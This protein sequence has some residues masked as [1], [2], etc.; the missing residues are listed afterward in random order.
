MNNGSRKKLRDL[1]ARLRQVLESDFA[2]GSS[3]P[4]GIK[5]K[6]WH[7]AVHMA[8]EQAMTTRGICGGIPAFLA[9]AA[10]RLDGRPADGTLQYCCDLIAAREEEHSPFAAVDSL[11]WLHQYW[12]DG[13]RQAITVN[14]G[15]GHYN[16]ITADQIIP[17][18]QVYSERYIVDFLVQ[19]SLG[20]LW[21]GMHPESALAGA[22]RYYVNK[23][24]GARLPVKPAAAITVVDPAC[25]CGNFLLAAFDLLYGMHREEGGESPEKI[26]ASILNDN[27][28]GL[29]IDAEAVEIAR[30]VLWLRAKE[31]APGLSVD[32][33]N[34][35]FR[36]LVAAGTKELPPNACELGSLLKAGGVRKAGAVLNGLLSRRY[37]VV[38]TNP[39]YIDKRDYSKTVRS[40][41]R[42]H[43]PAGAGNL[44]AAFILRCLDL[45]G[46]FVGMITPQ[47]FLFLTSYAALRQA[48]FGEASIR[49]L[50]HLGLG[51]FEDAVVDTAMF[52]LQR[53]ASAARQ[54]VEGV[55]FKLLEAPQK[56][57]ALLAAV[58]GAGRQP[59]PEDIYCR[60][61]EQVTALDGAPVTYWLGDGMLEVVRQARPLRD[62]ADIVLGMKT[63]DNKRFV[64]YWWEVEPDGAGRQ[65]PEWAPYEKEASGY[66]FARASAHYVRWSEEARRFYK[67]HYSAQL[68]NRRYWFRPGLVYGLVSSKAFTAKLL[69]AG[70]MADMAASCVYPHDPADGLFLLGILNSKL[71]QWLLKLF[72]PTVNYQPV[73][74]QRLPVPVL[75]H[76]DKEEI[77]SLAA[78]AAESIGRVREREIT[79]RNYCFEPA[80]FL[81]P[82][83]KLA[84]QAA[85]VWLDSL[86]YILAREAIDLRL[87]AALNLPPQEYGTIMAEM[88]GLSVEYPAVAGYDT[89]P[90]VM[91][92]GIFV[93]PAR[94]VRLTAEEL[95]AV[96]VRLKD[97]YSADWAR[98]WPVTAADFMED[99]AAKL[100]LHPV[101]V[102]HLIGEGVSQ[103]GWGGGSLVKRLAEDAFSAVV[104]WLMGHRWPR[105]PGVGGDGQAALVPVEP[106]W[107]SDSILDKVRGFI[108]DH[109]DPATAE[110]EFHFL[111][112][113]TLGNWLKEVFFRRH[114]SQFKKRPV[115][116]QL[117]GGRRGSGAFSCFI[118]HRQ[119]GAV[120]QLGAG[121]V[122]PLLGR[123]D[124][125]S[126][127][128]AADGDNLR[129]GLKAFA[130]GL[131]HLE[132]PDPNLDLGIRIRVALFQQ[133]G[134]LKTAVLSPADAQRAVVDYRLWR[135]DFF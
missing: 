48:V 1:T 28:F 74:L 66:R 135:E 96:K 119:A 60:T 109:C 71:Y 99:A 118:H 123:V 64:R 24:A 3:P 2:A 62:Y 26:C 30:T 44:Y 100:K 84:A 106:C 14:S 104:L 103:E 88:G 121:A 95:A 82:G 72:N 105:Q 129:T 80:A 17:A 31:L 9:M 124:K 102:Y 7:W 69:P 116:W 47:T 68:P 73:D 5:E 43:Y 39:P 55:Y 4:K 133:A 113:E 98:G 32:A 61:L 87:A 75:A 79:D 111:V 37:D 78:E 65:T 13:E 70:H 120:R 128:G 122:E 11:G 42:Q 108:G 101:T 92:Q 25:G 6:A 38:V 131:A 107:G 57:A 76:G 81:P 12:H 91:N 110:E 46:N 53:P 18:T 45:S 67:S 35:F 132:E 29:D 89:L 34:G 40:Y 77:S 83:E 33:L 49:T 114:V 127:A 51:T 134:L 20:A 21:L 85:G 52:V 23:P 16:K 8:V 27:L 117:G 125:L 97:M 94:R 59:L 22:W 90:A 115:V 41:L 93:S 126:A 58:A 112:G 130:A 36:H 19:N 56:E 15:S 50:A 86:R 63:S 10:S 54:P